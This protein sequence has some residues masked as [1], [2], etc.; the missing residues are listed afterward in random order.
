MK[1]HEK[2]LEY[3]NRSTVSYSLQETFKRALKTQ[4]EVL[5]RWENRG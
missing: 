2:V 5:K 1:K 3:Q 4:L